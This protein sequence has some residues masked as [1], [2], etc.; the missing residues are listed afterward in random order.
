MKPGEGLTLALSALYFFTLLAGYS[1]LRPV[2][3]AMGLSGGA[4]KLP[5]LFTGT[6]IGMILVN[7]AFAWLVTRV[8]RRVFIPAVYVISIAFLI[9]FRVAF[10][11]VPKSH[12]TWIAYPYFAFVSVFNLFVVSVFW[13][14][15]ADL[16]QLE[17]AKR[18]Y[19]FI[20]AG[21]TLG[22]FVGA[23]S[24]T[25]LATRM[26]SLN[27]LYLSAGMLLLSIG[28]IQWLMH[29]HHID[30]VGERSRPGDEERH[31][32]GPPTAADTWRGVKLVGT[33]P[34]LRTIASY[35][36][37]Y[38]LIGTFLYFQQGHLVES[39]I[40]NRDD[41]TR[42]FG[43]VDTV[44][45]SMT[46]LIQIFFTGRLI[47]RFGIT[48]ALNT[49]PVIAL[50]GWIALAC[51]MLFGPSLFAP[52]SRLAGLTPELC[53]LVVVQVLLRASN[54]ATARPARESLYTVVGREMKYKSK[55]FIDTFVYRFADATGGWTFAG[56]QWAGLA[57]PAI[58]VVTIPLT[59][60]WILVGRAL[61][62]RQRELV[63]E[64]SA[65]ETLGNQTIASKSAAIA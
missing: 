55:S 59:G 14:F 1:I 12:E 43:I 62:R 3:E 40:P 51:T 5:L 2:R 18:L 65:A 38:G 27:L 49:Q 17:Q 64:S 11:L 52:G 15:M 4:D 48:F 47:K 9:G 57:L 42:Y 53:V 50:V 6:M 63:A 61:G 20:G 29:I 21:G 31:L 26:G 19:G 33:N 41:R 44:A 8:R 36:F 10:D 54:F 45:Q 32:R 56:L 16:W 23:L 58:A 22:A 35:T 30:R 28:C 13:G 7:P 34:Y 24:T 39:G 60:V 37:L 25:W 46:G